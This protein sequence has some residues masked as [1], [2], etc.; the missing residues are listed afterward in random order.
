MKTV[1]RKEA[2]KFINDQW[3]HWIS[4]VFV[5]RTTGENREMVFRQGVKKYVK[6]EEGNGRPYNFEEHGLLPVWEASKE[7]GGEDAYRAIPREGIIRIKM[8]GEWFEVK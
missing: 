4:V 2:L 7:H 8:N 1:T 6:G 5:K 3:G